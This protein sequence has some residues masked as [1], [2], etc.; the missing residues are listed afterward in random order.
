[1]CE[2]LAYG[3]C[4]TAERSEIEPASCRSLVHPSYHHATLAKVAAID[5]SFLKGF[6]HPLSNQLTNSA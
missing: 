2:R 6:L 4:V 3:R 1:M 5:V